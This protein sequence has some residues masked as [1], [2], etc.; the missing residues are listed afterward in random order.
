MLAH[1]LPRWPAPPGVFALFTLRGHSQNQGAS[2]G[3]YRYLNLGLHVG[4]APTAVVANRARLQRAL[5]ARPVFLNQVHGT[6]ALLLAPDTADGNTADAALTCARG[7]ACAVMVADC[8]PVLLTTI[9]GTVVA[10]AH[11]G[12]RG[13]AAGVLEQTVAAVRDQVGNRAALLAWL[14][15]CIGPAAFEVGSEVRAAFV[16]HDRQA[17]R[18]F[19]PG[20]PHK[21]H[22]DL[23]A[24]ARL[25]LLALGD[26]AL[27]GNDGSP[28]WCTVQ[29]K[30]RFYSHRRDGTT[31]GSGR[32][33]ACIWRV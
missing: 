1:W 9:D 27:Y 11:A 5:G 12:W 2:R 19:V 8:L 16:A 10:A 29:N 24:L 25:R 21:Y 14:G 6:A 3:P 30:G 22:A 13:L 26:I 32:H 23:A 20:R 7:L 33:A 15:P 4:D 31:G 28:S 17:A 18:Y